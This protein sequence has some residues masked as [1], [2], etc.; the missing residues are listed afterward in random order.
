MEKEKAALQGPLITFAC[1]PFKLICLANSLIISEDS[2]MDFIPFVKNLIV[3]LST[4]L[5]SGVLEKDSERS[6]IVGVTDTS[7]NCV[8]VK[9]FYP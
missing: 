6:L 3:S 8:I 1:L 5:V 2:L 7:V 9:A 4:T